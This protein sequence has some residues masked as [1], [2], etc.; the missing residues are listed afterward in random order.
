MA[1]VLPKPQSDIIPISL[2]LGWGSGAFGA[3]VL[4]N[5]ISVFI[6]FYLVGILKIEPAL[7]GT[8]VFIAKVFD[9]ITDPIVGIWS[10]RT[11]SS[12]GRRR[13]FI[14]WGAVISALSFAIIFNTPAFDSQWVTAAYV[15]IA[16]CIYAVGYTLFNVPYMSM[17]AEMTDDYHERSSIHAYRIIFVVLGSFLAASIAP[18]VVEKM[19][20][21]EPSSYGALGIFAGV[22]I[23]ISMVIAYATTAKARFTERS[24]DKPKLLDEFQAIR[25]NKH[26]LRLIGVKFAQLLG[27]QAIQA[28]MIFFIIQSLQLELTIFVLFG[29]VSTITS[30]SVAPLFLRFSR[31]F[32]KS[33]AYC[34]SAGANV[35]Y[36]LS[37]S[38]AE[39]GEPMWAI[40][41]RAFFVGIAMTGNIVMAMSMLTDIINYDAKRTGIRREGAYTSLYSFVEKFTAA[42]GPMIIGFALSLAN[43]DTSLPPDVPQGAQVQ[44]ALLFAVSWLPAFFGVISIWLLIGYKLTEEEINNVGVKEE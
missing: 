23:F 41:L 43:F 14:L 25:Q 26:F 39:P 19:G 5:G 12:R 20:R 2:K 18:A 44:T 34:V 15:L 29:I 3:A 37:W 4:V 10:D 1:T 27:I 31:R 22:L 6:F 36:A 21:A 8:I 40:G 30:I 11:S 42:L 17:P 16:L 9:F 32:G 28:A 7:A 38:W 35:L 13:P 33:N 24:N